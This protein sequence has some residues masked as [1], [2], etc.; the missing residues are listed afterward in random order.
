[1]PIKHKSS[2]GT[3]PCCFF[4]LCYALNITRSLSKSF[5]KT[6]IPTSEYA[7]FDAAVIRRLIGTDENEK[8]PDIPC[9]VLYSG[10][11]N[12]KNS[13]LGSDWYIVE[14]LISMTTSIRG[15]T[16]VPASFT[17][18]ASVDTIEISVMN[19]STVESISKI[20]HRKSAA[21]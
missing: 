17:L 21:L 11:K 10:I 20:S 13:A 7:T 4:I 5:V 2:I 8:I 9:I 18:F 12:Q 16:I 3:K 6:N 15:I 19:R 1:M 14:K